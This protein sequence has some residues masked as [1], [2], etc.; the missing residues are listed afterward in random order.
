MAEHIAE[1]TTSIWQIH[2][3]CEGNTRATAVF[4]IKYL[5]S[6]G[7]KGVSNNLFAENSWYFRNAL[8]RAAATNVAEGVYPDRIYIDRFFCN[9]LLGE[10]HILRNRDLHINAEK[11]ATIKLDSA[12]AIAKNATIKPKNATINL[13]ATQKAVL[14]ILGGN[15]KITADNIASD[16]GKDIGTIKRA[17]RELKEKGL[18]ER[19]GSNK[20]GYWKVKGGGE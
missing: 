16:I 11:N 17:I 5:R 14:E 2:P 13:S 7:F 1:F 12:T 8:V 15:G 18:L 19:I 20:T 3:F 6:L 9:L 4:I 10:K